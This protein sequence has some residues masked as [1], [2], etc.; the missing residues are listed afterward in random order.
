MLSL[1]GVPI[2]ESIQGQAFL[3]DQKAP[4]PRKYLYAARDRMDTEYDTRRAVRDKRFKY[5]KNYKPDVGRYQEIQYR[6]NM[7]LMNELLRLRDAGELNEEQMKY[8][9]GSKPQEELYDTWNDPYELNNL[10]GDA[11]YADTLERLRNEHLAFLDKYPDLGFTPEKELLEEWWPGLE[12]PVSATPSFTIK[13]D[14]V[15]IN[16]QDEGATIA[17]QLVPVGESVSQ[18]WADW[19]IYSSP[20]LVPDSLILHAIAHRIGYKESKLA[21]FGAAMEVLNTIDG[22]AKNNDASGLTIDQMAFAGVQDIVREYLETYK[23]F[24][25]AED[26]VSDLTHLQ[27]IVREANAFADIRA[28]AAA[29]DASGLTAKHLTAL[30]IRIDSR[31]MD[32]YRKAIEQAEP[33]DIIDIE[34]VQNLIYNFNNMD[35][36]KGPSRWS[37]YPNPVFDRLHIHGLAG[38]I[39]VSLHDIQG[40]SVL[41]K[42]TACPAFIDFSMFPAGAYILNIK[43]QTKRQFVK[44]IK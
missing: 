25:E 2:P 11:A 27:R 28:F 5:I 31:E 18:N 4:T 6:L 3:G 40:Q 42:K 26:G 23:K 33:E 20:L 10:A 30:G 9:A 17:Y 12:Q 21:A 44:I 15:G 1:A 7:D 34:S 37:V 36:D 13:N 39:H 24:I 41:D 35:M 38:N 19:K 14:S 29:N 16:C 22:Y 43:D 8:F 32:S